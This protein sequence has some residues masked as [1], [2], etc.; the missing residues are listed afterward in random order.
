MGRGEIEGTYPSRFFFVDQWKQVL[1]GRLEVGLT[2]REVC[3]VE[4][5]LGLGPGCSC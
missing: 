3:N 4:G 1:T 5:F 2:P